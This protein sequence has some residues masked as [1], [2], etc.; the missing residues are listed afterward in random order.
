MFEWTDK[1]SVQV[2]T[3]SNAPCI[4]DAPG[5]G[6]PLR[7]CVPAELR[8]VSP[9]ITHHTKSLNTRHAF[10]NPNANTFKISTQELSLL[11]TKPKTVA[12]QS[13]SQHAHVAVQ[14]S[15]VIFDLFL[16]STFAII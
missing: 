6:Y 7:S 10:E 13:S 11:L 2:E 9:G 8:A 12:V 4:I 3:N 14:G 1:K 5:L 16:S 15:E